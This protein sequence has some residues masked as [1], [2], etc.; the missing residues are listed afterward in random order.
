MKKYFV[1]GS[2]ILAASIGGASIAQA[3]SATCPDTTPA[4]IEALFTEFNNAWATKDPAKVTS[5]FTK[6]PVLLATV[7]N[8]PRTTPAEVNDYFVKFLQGSPVGKIDT[9]TVE[10]DCNTASR[11]GTWTV[12][13]TDAKTGAKTDV[14]ARY[15]FLYRYEDGA[16]KIDHLHS[17]MMPEK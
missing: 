5:L 9:S 7:S 12:T 6:E 14:K 10:I 3:K 16:W 8:K 17:S 11:L 15:S 1:A 13:L 2:V 4:Q